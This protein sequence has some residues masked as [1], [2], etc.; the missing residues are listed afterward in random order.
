MIRIRC[1]SASISLLMAVVRAKRK[2]PAFAR[3]QL[4]IEVFPA[5]YLAFF[6]L[7]ASGPKSL[8]VRRRVPR[9]RQRN[10]AADRGG[11]ALVIA[12]ELAAQHSFFEG[13]DK[14][15]DGEPKQPRLDQQRAPDV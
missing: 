12:S 8:Q 14:E 15:R 13:D 10:P 11:V 9:P 7:V 3:G 6:I 2:S 4:R 5:G 1:C